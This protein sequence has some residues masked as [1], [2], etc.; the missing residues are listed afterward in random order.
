MKKV[1]SRTEL[2]ILQLELWLEPARLGLITSIYCTL[3]P[4]LI[5]GKNAPYESLV[6][7]NSGLPDIGSGKDRSVILYLASQGANVNARDKYGL[8]PLHYAGMRG[9]D[10][11]AVDLLQLSNTN[12][13]VI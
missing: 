1:T 12:I 3:H 7:T 8:T 11:A 6:D 2:K 9:N 5:A 4:L 13:E 10:D